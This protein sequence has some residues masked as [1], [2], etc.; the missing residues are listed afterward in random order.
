MN[1][2]CCCC[3][4]AV[5]SPVIYH[6]GAINGQDV[7]RPAEE[8]QLTITPTPT[9][10][11]FDLQTEGDGVGVIWRGSGAVDVASTLP[12]DQWVTKVYLSLDNHLTSAEGGDGAI[13]YISKQMY[14]ISV[15]VEAIPEPSGFTL[16][17][18]ALGGLVFCTRRN[19][20][21]VA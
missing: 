4:V 2:P 14:S 8:T 18:M 17:A 19:E 3:K 6:V 21:R 20:R 16:A 9:D 10:G 13:A 7:S 11:D 1:R 12:A 15:G 5:R